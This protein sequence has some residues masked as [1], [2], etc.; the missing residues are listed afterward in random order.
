[1]QNTKLLV[2]DDDP[3]ICESLRLIGESSGFS[4]STS[5]SATEFYEKYSSFHPDIVTVDLNLGQSDG[6]ELLRKLASDQSETKIILISGYDEK[7]INS[8][9]LLGRSQHL[10][11]I[12]ALQKPFD[13]KQLRELLESLKNAL[14][15]TQETLANAIEKN[16]LLLFY[17]PKISISTGKFI[18]V[19]SLIRWVISEDKL[20]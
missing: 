20:I 10:N 5:N 3:S 2:V 9:L 6:I 12:A 17:Q 8:T 13:P 1:M 14:P 16:K 18:G 7:I 19:E 15:I 4:V 11:I